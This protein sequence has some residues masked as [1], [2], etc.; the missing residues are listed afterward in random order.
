MDR[1][2][3][4][5]DDTTIRTLYK[6]FFEKEGYSVS[7]AS[8]GEQA[9]KVALN[10]LPDIILLDILLPKVNGMTVMNQIR[11][12]DWGKK[13]PIIILTNVDPDDA[14]L[15]NI[16]HDQPTYYLLKANTTPGEVLE[17]VQE[18]LKQKKAAL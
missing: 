7:T 6:D 10:V 1:V 4:I 12:T 17:K 9:L 8:D 15:Q 18:I 3:I 5:E 11:A 16:V 14:L 13:E 2:L